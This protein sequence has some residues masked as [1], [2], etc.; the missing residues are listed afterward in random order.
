LLACGSA[1]LEEDSIVRVRSPFGVHGVEEAPTTRDGY[2]FEGKRLLH[3]TTM[4]GTLFTGWVREL[5]RDPKTS[6]IVYGPSYFVPGVRDTAL[7]YYH[8]TG[9]VGQAIL[10]YNTDPKRAFAVLEL[11]TG[12]MAGYGLP[13]QTVDFYDRDQ[14]LAKITSDTD[15]YFTFVEDA[16][17]RGVAVHLVLGNPRT[18]FARKEIARRL[19]PLWGRKG[20]PEPSRE[21]GE[22]IGADFAYRLILVDTLDPTDIG[23]FTARIT[24]EAVKGYFDRLDAD[25]IV[26][27]HISSRYFD[28]QPVL[29]NIVDDLGVVGYR[30][31]DDDNSSAGKNRSH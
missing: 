12:T 28:L 19:K 31:S 23:H 5:F 21:Y 6:E 11:G 22:P 10:A 25:G 4:S 29:A 7:A 20:D 26:L 16:R 17:R 14:E 2:R 30:L 1:V 8:R 3:G 24:R 27:I 18:T 15:E 13:G 9:P